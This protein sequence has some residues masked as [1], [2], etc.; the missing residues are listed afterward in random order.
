[1]KVIKIYG[2]T[3]RD[4]KCDLECENCG[5][6]ETYGGAYD[7]RNF[8][9]NVIPVLPCLIL[10]SYF[11]LYQCS[12]CGKSSNDLGIKKEHIP[13]KYPEGFQV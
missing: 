13:T 10:A 9:D 3:R 8:W 7:D 2:Q 1:M 5:N 6:K 4:C 11:Q 12:K